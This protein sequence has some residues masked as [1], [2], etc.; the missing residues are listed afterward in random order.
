VFTN[1]LTTAAGCDSTVITTVSLLPS[2]TT[3]LSGQSCNPA[4]VGVFTEALTNQFGCD[5]TVI[6]TITFNGI[7]PTPVSATTCDPNAAGVFT[8]VITTAAGC[9]STVVTTVTLLPS[10][11]TNLTAQ[12]CD[13]ANVGVFTQDLTN[14]F[15]CDS[16][17]ITT[18]TLLPSN[19][20]AIASSSC[21]PAQ[22][23]VFVYPLVNQFGCDSIVTETV[24]L[25][26]SSATTV[27]L[28]TCEQG[29]VGTVVEVLSNQFGCDSV[30]TT[31]TSLLPPASCG[32]TAELSGSTIPCGATTGTLTLTATLGEGPFGYTVLLGN[33]PVA[34]G[35]I[36][37]VGAPEIV[38][39]LAPG[40]YTVN[41]SSNNGFSATAQATIVQLFPPTLAVTNAS[42]YGGF[43]VSCPGAS[44]GSALATPSGGLPPYSYAWSSGANTQQAGNLAA[45]AYN[46]TI[47][48]A[49]NCTVTGSVALE[50]PAPLAITFT[51]NDPNCFGNSNGSI[52]VSA[53]GGVQPY[54][55]SINGGNPQASNVFPG[56][57][58]GS[59]TITAFDVNDCETA[60]IIAVNAALELNVDL[61]DDIYID[62][63][64]DATLQAVVNVPFDSL[65]SVIWSPMP[66]SSECPGCLTQT[67]FPLVSTSYSIQIV[68]NKGCR[69]ED[70]VLVVVNRRRHI[71]VPNVF[72]PD[73]DGANDMF[74]I[75]AKP[76]TVRNIRSL[77]LYDR[78]GENLFTLDNFLPND[79][80]LGWNGTFKGQA[81]NPGVFVWVMEVEFID[82]VVEIYK[83]DVTLSR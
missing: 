13:P 80:S 68:D 73:G 34:N 16:T 7:P 42:N 15:G 72:S 4:E 48:D 82:G 17:V 32:M 20:T 8:E 50:E 83:G 57:G 33:T 39:G 40:N 45:G 71:Y 10:N 76:G 61:G 67:V 18:V 19:T 58:A 14:Q 63:G 77:A 62:Q 28:G 78:W 79:P 35:T 66:D 69:D 29:E 37:D 65:A 25:L 55:F 6:T 26:P 64:D 51:V 53:T 81:M 49:N 70:K 11:V 56:L 5:S 36:A 47:T 60:E 22:V 74:S 44:D 9:D 1:V 52:I 21:D 43:E 30:V 38:S 24:T 75:F 12:D 2:S 31:V 41:Y 27:N 3:N 23:G 54:R 46:V 59:Y